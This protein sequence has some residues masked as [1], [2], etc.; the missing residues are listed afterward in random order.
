L[1]YLSCISVH[2]YI[3]VSV[4]YIG[5]L[6][7]CS[8]C[9]VYRYIV[10]LQY[11]SCISVHCYI[12]VSVLYIGTLL[13][14]S[15]CPVYR[16]IVTLQYL[17]CISVHCYIAVSVCISVQISTHHLITFTSFR[18]CYWTLIMCYLLF[19]KFLIKIS[20]FKYNWNIN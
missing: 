14:C 2:C 5:T 17:S 18:K 20:F 11:L 8:I 19:Y 13:Y 12:A 16:Y 15:I 7:H 6:S 4:L 9:P 3:A 10:T 1:Q